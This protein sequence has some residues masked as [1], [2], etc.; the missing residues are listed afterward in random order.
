MQRAI[1][2]ALA[3]V[4]FCAVAGAFVFRNLALS[5]FA[6]V[7]LL[8]LVITAAGPSRLVSSCGHLT[9]RAG[10]LRIWGNRPPQIA[11]D[12]VVLD[13]VWALGAGLHFSVSTPGEKSRTHIKV[14][15][16]ARWSVDPNSLTISDA[17]YVQVSGATVE[18][19]PGAPALQFVLSEPA[20]ST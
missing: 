9:G 2:V 1:T 13:R 17:K 18:R 14:A 3:V 15:Q 7:S 19:S 6:G 5:I 16:P 4:V 10:T 8:F 20:A 11:A 12:N